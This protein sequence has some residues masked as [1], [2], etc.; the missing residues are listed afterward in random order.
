MLPHSGWSFSNRENL[1]SFYR[2]GCIGNIYDMVLKITYTKKSNDF[3]RLLSM[4]NS[5]RGFREKMYAKWKA[6]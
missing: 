6:R 2:L 4:E 5:E 3:Y 1:H